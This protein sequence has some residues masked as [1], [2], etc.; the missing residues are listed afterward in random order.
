MTSRYARHFP[1]FAVQSTSPGREEHF[2]NARVQ[3]LKGAY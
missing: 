3:H 2:A 1:S